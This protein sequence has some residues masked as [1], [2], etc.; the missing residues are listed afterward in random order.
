MGQVSLTIRQT[1]DALLVVAAGMI[2]SEGILSEADRAIGDGDHGVGMARG[3]TAV[4]KKLAENEFSSLSE[5]FITVG[6]ALMMSIGGASG[7]IFGTLF[8]EGARNLPANEFT[9][10]A[11]SIF[12]NDGLIAVQKRGKANPG[13]KTMLDALF[14]AAKSAAALIEYPLDVGLPQVVAAAEVGMEATK[15]M[16]ASMGRAK[17]LGERSLGYPDPG[18]ISM[19]LILRFLNEAAQAK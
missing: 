17:T 11:L 8:R 13:D 10:T 16:V 4:E 5:L 2:A 3:F 18:A 7:A 14:P 19:L 9:S 6:T 15:N 1:R 12:L